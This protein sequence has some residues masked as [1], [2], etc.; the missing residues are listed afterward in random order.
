M[1]YYAE[2]IVSKIN[3]RVLS[4]L[5]DWSY[6]HSLYP[7]YSQPKLHNSKRG[8]NYMRILGDG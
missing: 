1:F 5:N 6:L 4:A 8:E 3:K 2:G 7:I